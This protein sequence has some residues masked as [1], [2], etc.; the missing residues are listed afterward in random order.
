MSRVEAG[1][2]LPAD[3]CPQ[4]WPD[5]VL[6][7][8]IGSTCRTW[9]HNLNKN[10]ILKMEAVGGQ[11]TDNMRSTLSHN[12]NKNAILKMEAVR[13][14]VTNSIC[15]TVSNNLNKN[16]YCFELSQLINKIGYRRRIKVHIGRGH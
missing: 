13:G 3:C 14:Q 15:R 12:H 9:N 7:Q 8:V 4:T 2:W 16:R 6:G 5:L 10:T 1:S 11:V